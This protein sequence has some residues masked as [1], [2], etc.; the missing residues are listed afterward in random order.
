MGTRPCGCVVVVKFHQGSLQVTLRGVKPTPNAF[1]ER[2]NGSYRN[3]VLD[4]N[5][6]ESIEQLW[7]ISD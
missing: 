1:I 6:F 7:Q 3:R 4:A 5:V 2:F